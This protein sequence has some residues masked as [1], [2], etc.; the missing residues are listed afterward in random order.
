MFQHLTKFV[1]KDLVL[2]ILMR[3]LPF[4]PI[5]TWTESEELGFLAILLKST[6]TTKAWAFSNRFTKSR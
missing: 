6:L 1:R 3:F 4:I 5:T 2:F